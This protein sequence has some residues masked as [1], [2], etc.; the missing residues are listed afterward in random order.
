MKKIRQLFDGMTMEQLLEVVLQNSKKSD[1][2]MVCVIFIRMRKPFLSKYERNKIW[3]KE[4][5]EDTLNDFFIY[6]REGKQKRNIIRYEA[7]HRI[8]DHKKF[9]PWI[10]RAYHFY[11]TNCSLKKEELYAIN[12][13][14]I[15]QIGSK[16]DIEPFWNYERKI[17]VASK[18]IAYVHQISNEGHRLIF[19]Y[20][21]MRHYKGEC[22]H[23]CQEIA[24]MLGISYLSFRVKTSCIRKKINKTRAQLLKTGVLPLDGEHLRMSETIMNNFNDL[25]PIFLRYYKRSLFI[26]TGIILH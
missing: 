16:N 4:S 6:L 10:I 8:K 18:V 23:S 5:F 15:P 24:S 12:I 19:A 20:W 25:T 11:L 3:L 9:A 26:R 17:H 21:L 1:L 2:A 14:D 7:L 13:D 22:P